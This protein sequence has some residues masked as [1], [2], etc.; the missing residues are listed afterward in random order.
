MYEMCACMFACVGLRMCVCVCMCV[1]VCV[2][3]FTHFQ[4]NLPRRTGFKLNE[5]FHGGEKDP[6]YFV[7]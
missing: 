2:Y 5:G 7:M 3:H 4:P 6:V 1:Y